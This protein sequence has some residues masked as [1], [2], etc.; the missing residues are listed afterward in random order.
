MATSLAGPT[1]DEPIWLEL[2]GQD[3][4]WW[5]RSFDDPQPGSPEE[6]ELRQALEAIARGQEI[7][8]YSALTRA[9]L[10]LRLRLAAAGAQAMSAEVAKP[11]PDI[12]DALLPGGTLAE[13]RMLLLSGMWEMWRQLSQ[14]ALMW[15]FEDAG[16]VLALR[17]IQQRGDANTTID[18][19]QQGFA[20]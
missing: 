8:D 20:A 2:A 5:L 4:Q 3:Y 10:V 6:S 11:A 9:R 14:T 13:H 12:A 19:T 15:G 16:P 17:A 1:L 7:G 18:P